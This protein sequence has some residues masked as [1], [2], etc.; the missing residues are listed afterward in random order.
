MI[1]KWMPPLCLHDHIHQKKIHLF[2][3]VTVDLSSHRMNGY[4]IVFIHLNS[5]K[6]LPIKIVTKFYDGEVAMVFYLARRFTQRNLWPPTIL[7][8]K[9]KWLSCC[10]ISTHKVNAACKSQCILGSK[11]CQ[12]FRRWIA[13]LVAHIFKSPIVQVIP[14]R[15]VALWC[16]YW[17]SQ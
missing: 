17:L 2:C 4:I 9:M 1:L 8:C 7:V 12:R 14:H 3:W 15:N 10:D 13:V 16:A 11:I 5:N 6:W